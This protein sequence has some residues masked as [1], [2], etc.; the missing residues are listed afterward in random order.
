MSRT[1]GILSKKKRVQYLADFE[2]T[3]RPSAVC[4]DKN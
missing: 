4:D 1:P 2:A 3:D